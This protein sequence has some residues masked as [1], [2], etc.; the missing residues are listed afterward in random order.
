MWAKHTV[1]ISVENLV[2][3]C[4]FKSCLP[5]VR[6][7]PGKAILP[8]RAI[9]PETQLRRVVHGREMYQQEPN[10][11]AQAATCPTSGPCASP[12]GTS[13]W[14]QKTDTRPP[15]EGPED[16]ALTAIASLADEV[17]CVDPDVCKRICG[18]R[19]GCSNI[20]YPKLVIALMPTGES[21]FL[22]ATCHSRHLQSPLPRRGCVR[23]DMDRKRK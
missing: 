7:R 14:A 8:P 19:V 23:R 1:T 5:F 6:E 21:C 16:P 17:G 9:R 3:G 13:L 2:S 4:H 10:R 22:R 15:R 11:S 12:V 20:A 18:A